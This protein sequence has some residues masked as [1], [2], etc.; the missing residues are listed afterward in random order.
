VAASSVS[1]TLI[2]F[3]DVMATLADVVGMKLPTEAGPD[4]VSFYP[5][6]VGAAKESKSLRKNLVVG[7]SI[8]VGDWK[9]IEGYEPLIFSRPDAG[10]TPDRN[11]PPGLLFDL[12]S[13]PH[14]TTN[15]A[16]TEPEITQG[17]QAEFKRVRNQP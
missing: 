13:D 3:T 9:W 16:Q 10:K 17:L 1:D 12:A 5:T 2:G 4:S 7:N 14:E 8:R 6:L 15:L 11:D